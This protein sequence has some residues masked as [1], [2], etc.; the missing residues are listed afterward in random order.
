MKAKL[1]VF[2]YGNLSR[3]DDALAPLLAETI[4]Q[5]FSGDLQLEVLTDFQLQIEHALD[6][7]GRELV[8]FMDA[9]V[10]STE[11]FT[12]SE[13]QAEKDKSYTT[14]AMSPAS[15]LQVYQD[16]IKT[17]LPPCFLLTIQ[18]MAFEL[19]E[20]L[21]AEAQSN[22]KQ[23]QAFIMPLLHRPELNFWREQCTGAACF[24]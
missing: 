21:S 14:H 4:E 11:I 13:L 6:I 19:G 5:D 10:N 2:A 12:L 24:A 23:A 17:P 15:V 20:P 18:G 3:G 16:I 9:S 8:L 1:L 22:L 7:E